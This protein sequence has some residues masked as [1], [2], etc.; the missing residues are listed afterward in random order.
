MKGNPYVYTSET[1][2]EQKELPKNLVIIGGGY[3]GVE[4]SSIYASFGSKVS[5]LQDGDVFLPREDADIAGAVR[6]SLSGRG[7]DVLTS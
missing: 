4:F 3:I 7:I 5:I 1:L 2:L 6:K